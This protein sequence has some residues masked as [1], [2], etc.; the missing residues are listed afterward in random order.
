MSSSKQSAQTVPYIS[1]WLFLTFL[2]I[3]CGSAILHTLQSHSKFSWHAE[4]WSDYLDGKTI[5]AFEKSFEKELP[6]KDITTG[7]WGAFRYG[8]F[9]TGAQGVIIGENEWLF[10][11]EEFELDKDFANNIAH[12][13]KVIELVDNYLRQQGVALLVAFVPAKSRIL[14]EY[15]GNTSRPEQWNS[16]IYPASI[17]SQRPEFRYLLLDEALNATKKQGLPFMRTDTHWS[18]LG[19]RAAATSIA[20]YIQKHCSTLDLTKESYQTMAE[21]EKTYDGDLIDFVPTGFARSVLGPQSEEYEA[22]RTES[23]DENEVTDLFG[24]KTIEVA[25]IGTSYSAQEQWNF[26]GFLKEALQTDVLNLSDEGGGPMAP[27]A[28]FL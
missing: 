27:M 18:P 20:S 23:S 5:A 9:R 1:F 11:R 15:L 8:I 24:D 28:A 4:Q 12:N 16:S 17:L 25:L 13:L 2:I 10:T 22:T 3:V 19:A 6:Y 7:L 26:S 14:S 21:A